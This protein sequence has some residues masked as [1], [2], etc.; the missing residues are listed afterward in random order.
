M[1]TPERS[2]GHFPVSGVVAVLLVLTSAFIVQQTSLSSSRPST[3]GIQRTTRVAA[4]QDVDARLW[5]DPFAAV[6]RH[7]KN[8]GSSGPPPA[9]SAMER[10]AADRRDVRRITEQ[11]R[12]PPPASGQAAGRQAPHERTPPPEVGVLAAM[13]FGGPY[14]EDAEHRRR[15]RYATLSALKVSGFFPE[16][17]EHIGY[18]EL[19]R[20][21]DTGLENP[22]LPVAI[23][24]EWF[25]RRSAEGRT[26]L[27]VL[28]LDELAFQAQ[29]LRQ[30]TR[31]VCRLLGASGACVAGTV[32]PPPAWP[33][34][35]IL[36][37]AGS[38]SLRAMVADDAPQPSLRGTLTFYSPTT[39]TSALRLLSTTGPATS[40]DAAEAQL[41]QVFRGRETPL[42][43]VSV[44]DT[45]VMLSLIR[46]LR[47]RGVDLG[48]AAR[49]ADCRRLPHVALISEWDTVYGQALPDAFTTAMQH[50]AGSPAPPPGRTEPCPVVHRFSYMRGLDGVVRES[51]PAPDGDKKTKEPAG[52][53]RPDD[54][55]E[56]AEGNGQID[57]L[58]RL[59]VRLREEDRRLQHAD[60]GRIR[61]IGVLGSDVYDKLLVLQAVR[62]DFPDAVLFTTD[63]DARLLAPGE[64]RRTRNL[65]VAAGY[66]LQLQH[67]LQQDIAPFRNTDQTATF[68]AA[69]L[70]AER[71]LE[72]STTETAQ[73]TAREWRRTASVFELGR[74]AAVELTRPPA[75][76]PCATAATCITPRPVP[77][78]YY[79]QHLRPG[80]RWAA[81]F[82]IV[83]G[84][85]LLW[86]SSW[87]VRG[88]VQRFVDGCRRRLNRRRPAFCAT[89]IVLGLVVLLAVYGVVRALH[90]ESAEPF[91]LL[92]GVSVWPTEALRFLALLVAIQ[93]I[94]RVG[95]VLGA[96]R[97]S[98]TERFFPGASRDLLGTRAGARHLL[99]WQ[100]LR[101]MF[102]G[103][104]RAERPAASF[105]VERAWREHLFQSSRLARGTRV[106]A[107]TL[108]FLLLGLILIRY[109]FRPPHIPYRGPWTVIIDQALLYAAVVSVIVLL[110]L[111]VDEIRLCDKLARGLARASVTAWPPATREQF[112]RE[113]E[114]PDEVLAAWIDTRLIAEWTRVMTPLVYWPSVVIVLLMIARSSLLDAWDLPFGLVLV[115]VLSGSYAVGCAF[116]LRRVAER[117]RALTVDCLGDAIYRATGRL[118]DDRSLVERLKLLKQR[119][120]S[121]REG[122]FVPVTQQPIMKAVALP[123]S[124]GAGLVVL[125]Y[126]MTHYMMTP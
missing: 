52:V 45:T 16:D 58:R 116:T 20:D 76:G 36:G 6:E 89:V 34:I 105:A 103:G 75:A 115:F 59:A 104:D 121:I 13:V 113:L 30:M 31:L 88:L 64:F 111:V 94:V 86:L 1:A 18:V 83:V 54:R 41:E 43:R 32:S 5:E 84:F 9:T 26:R 79:A 17:A 77:P 62:G 108:L 126:L 110:F 78:G 27:L 37:P 93:G 15:A 73:K 49:S 119:V 91:A 39:T 67:D 100:G 51:A 82:A 33:P 81:P 38:D 71:L 23:P 40:E 120:E 107:M 118:D 97:L 90:D 22:P 74:T 61:A 96:A 42:V 95:G 50:D 106:T 85:G 24:Y 29:P 69:R 44:P 2:D 117:A 8:A 4:L 102:A 3:P 55:L 60:Q 98:L 12:R 66:G 57:Y 70:A 63:L 7:R 48:G 53:P 56:K 80:V 68:L 11:L 14:P 122:A 99:S 124:S 114:V 123:I 101:R 28:W 125:Q 92:E 19:G 65:V 109:V 47:V 25:V 87:T 10:A 46:E 72:I 21:R 35:V 112:R